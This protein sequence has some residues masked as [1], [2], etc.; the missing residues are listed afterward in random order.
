MV[1]KML[2]SLSLQTRIFDF[3]SSAFIAVLHEKDALDLGVRAL[4]RVEVL[5]PK[6]KRSAVAVIDITEREVRKGEIGLF[7]ELR[8][9]L[10]IK[11]PVKVEVRAVP[12]LESVSFIRKKIRGEKLS[13]VEIQKIVQDINAGKISELELSAFMTSVFIRGF[14]IE[15]TVSM[16]NAL[17]SNGKRIEFAKK[18]IV[19]KHCIGGI[20]GRS[21]LVLVPVIAAAG[22]CIPKT[23]SK[24]ITSAAGTA[25]SM[26]CLANASLPLKKLKQVVEKTNACIAW[27]GALDLAPVD[28][29][30]IKVEHPLKL[31]P[32]GQIIAS[33]M[34]KK[35]AVGS[36]FVVID[37]PVGPEVKLASE[38]KALE[39]SEKFKKVGEALGI[40]V[41]SLITN[42]RLPCGPAFGP[43]LE[44]KHALQILEGRVFDSM[45]EKSCR[46]A[47][48]LFSMVEECSEEQGFKRAKEIIES[49]KALEKMQEIIQAQGGKRIS[50]EGISVGRFMQA[51]LAKRNGKI[52]S[53]SVKK[54]ATIAR[55]AGAPADKGAGVWISAMPGSFVRK[56]DVL[57]EIFAENERKLAEALSLAEK[58]EP[59]EIA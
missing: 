23:S 27:G 31:D 13:S 57:F 41:K 14:D 49:G 54:L 47:A 17:L 58:L 53:A 28:D 7:E 46:L 36:K 12:A 51:V 15:E 21:T 40:K 19:D 9:E 44:A 10:L 34:A 42:G 2:Y 35:A 24:A 11:K 43:A 39:I 38:E 56:N 48:V 6:L 30:I 45:A 37:L 1:K 50:S 5:N 3:H 20:N 16:T 4:D 8:K 25:D 22:Y 32:Q 52:V 59:M 29:K 26:E 18:P 55:E 33:V